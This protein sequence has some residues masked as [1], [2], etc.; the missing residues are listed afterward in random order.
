MRSSDQARYLHDIPV[1]DAIQSIHRYG[2]YLGYITNSLVEEIEPGEEDDFDEFYEGDEVREQ[3]L[4]AMEKYFKPTPMCI[5]GYVPSWNNYKQLEARFMW[6]K[7][8]D[9]K[10]H[11]EY[12]DES[13]GDWKDLGL[14]GS[15][16]VKDWIKICK[17]AT[18][19]DPVLDESVR[20]A[21]DLRAENLR[22]RYEV[23]GQSSIAMGR[24]PEKLYKSLEEDDH[25]L[26]VSYMARC[27]ETYLM[28]KKKVKLIPYKLNVYQAGGFFK[29]HVDTPVLADTMLGIVVLCFPHDFK[30]GEL[31]VQNLDHSYVFDFASEREKVKAE[32]PDKEKMH[33]A[34]FFSDS[35]HEV[36]PVLSG[37]RVTLTYLIVV[38]K[39]IKRNEPVE[40]KMQM[41]ESDS[42][43]KVPSNIQ[44]GPMMDTVL[45]AESMCAA[46][47]QAIEG[48]QVEYLGVLLSQKYTHGMIEQQNLKGADAGFWEAIKNH[49]DPEIIP[50]VVS[51][52]KELQFYGSKEFSFETGVYSF[53]RNDIKYLKKN[54]K[55]PNKSLKKK[56]PSFIPFIEL[57]RN[58]QCLKY[59]FQ[60]GAEFTGNE[61]QPEVY[62]NLYFSAAV[63]LDFRQKK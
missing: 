56:Y 52:H 13:S 7:K 28:T 35:I 32:N 50:V 36:K 58:F 33:F 15:V 63:I 17:P 10:I 25:V 37:T 40:L 51:Y 12:K 43:V 57:L 8:R 60:Q 20:S 46:I 39:A 22:F 49:F 55:P 48:N 3:V 44:L 4:G 5:G 59:E 16:S 24:G 23:S 45:A 31:L 19:G 38:D 29:P 1:Y 62:D 26:P 11:L 27:V 9:A 47:E 21:L 30:G 18:F 14:V 61:A 34:A 41:H 53:S 42:F 2:A 54:Q 6:E